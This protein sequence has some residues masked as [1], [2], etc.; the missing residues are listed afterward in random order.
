MKGSKFINDFLSH[1]KN[2]PM[3]LKR[4]YLTVWEKNNEMFHLFCS[5][6]EL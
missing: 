3:T 5:C 1:L 6:K 2:F 4:M